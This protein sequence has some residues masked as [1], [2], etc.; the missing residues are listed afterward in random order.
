MRAPQSALILASAPFPL[1]YN[2]SVF[3]SVFFPL[4]IVQENPRFPPGPRLIRPIG[5]DFSF[6][7]VFDRRVPSISVSPSIP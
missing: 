6:L 2:G 7:H 4:E 1:H 3:T 5:N